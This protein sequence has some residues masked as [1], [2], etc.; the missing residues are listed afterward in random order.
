MIRFV[1]AMALALRKPITHEADKVAELAEEVRHEVFGLT[2]HE[3][4]SS[5]VQDLA[6]SFVPQELE[7]DKAEFGMRQGD[8]VGAS[9]V[10]E[11]SRT[12][13]KVKLLFIQIV[14]VLQCFNLNHMRF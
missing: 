6:A 8:T 9:A 4:V 7:V 11:L 14:V 10:G 2:F 5:S 13:N 12:V 3:F 1:N